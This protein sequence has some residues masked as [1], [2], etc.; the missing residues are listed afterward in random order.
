[1]TELSNTGHRQ[2]G[3][4]SGRV[5]DD[6]SKVKRRGFI[7]IAAMILLVF[8]AFWLANLKP[9]VEVTIGQSSSIANEINLQ[10][11][12]SISSMTEKQQRINYL[13]SI[14]VAKACGI[15]SYMAGNPQ[16][17]TD[18]EARAAAKTT[19][20]RR[21]NSPVHQGDV[22]STRGGDRCREASGTLAFSQR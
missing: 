13:D 6:G 16:P 9:T 18:K 21:V 10:R 8:L 14:R 19:D 15:P 22:L 3:F 1:M 12:D 7:A 11:G 5:E 2:V 20:W 4:V 17:L